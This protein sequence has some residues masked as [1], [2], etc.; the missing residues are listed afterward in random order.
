[1]TDLCLTFFIKMAVSCIIVASHIVV[2]RLNEF[3][4][5]TYVCGLSPGFTVDNLSSLSPLFIFPAVSFHSFGFVWV[6]F[7]FCFGFVWV[8]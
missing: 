5:A 8:D 4:A 6:M 7:R 2:T 1:M 3:L